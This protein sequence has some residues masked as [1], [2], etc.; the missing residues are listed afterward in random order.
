M[1][2]YDYYLLMFIIERCYFLLKKLEYILYI[3][4]LYYF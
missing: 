4:I 1:F 3:I 2:D